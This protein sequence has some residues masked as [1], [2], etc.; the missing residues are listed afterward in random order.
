MFKVERTPDNRW[1]VSH[2]VPNDD[3]PTPTVKFFDNEQRANSNA[4]ER[5]GKLALLS[6]A[7]KAN[8]GVGTARLTFSTG[9]VVLVTVSDVAGDAFETAFIRA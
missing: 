2:Y 6:A 1:S 3:Q 9:R 4:L 5:A 8:G 7:F